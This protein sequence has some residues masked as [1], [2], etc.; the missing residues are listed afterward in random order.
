[1]AV[2]SRSSVLLHVVPTTAAAQQKPPARRRVPRHASSSTIRGFG[3]LGATRF[4]AGD[5][6][7][8]TLGSSSGVFFG[9]GVEVVLPQQCFLDVRLSHFSKSGERVFVEDR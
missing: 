7:D 3:D 6:F 8:A 4:A 5:T 1:M 9:G 2:R